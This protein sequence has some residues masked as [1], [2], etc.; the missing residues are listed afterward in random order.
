MELAPS[1]T[2]ENKYHL[3]EGQK[4]MTRMLGEFH[5]LCKKY[6]LE[7]W[8]IGGTFVGAVMYNGWLPWDGDMDIAMIDT[9]FD[10]FKQHADELSPTTWLQTQQTD[11][12]Y[13]YRNYYKL[14]DLNS[15][16]INYTPKNCHYG[17][18]IDIFTFKKGTIVK[19]TWYPYTHYVRGD[20]TVDYAYDTIFPLKETAFDD[21][22]VYMPNNPEQVIKQCYEELYVPPLKNRRPHEGLMISDRPHPDDIVRYKHLYEARGIK[23]CHS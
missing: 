11:K 10:L 7:Y 3:R 9:D 17:L 22:L 19:P 16:Y 12:H 20:T 4:K 13:P 5:A 6:K 18:M 1:L 2:E 15:H 14:R 23:T 21:I 8:V